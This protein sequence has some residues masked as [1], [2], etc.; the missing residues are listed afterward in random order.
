MA[1]FFEAFAE[2]GRPDHDGA[3][4]LRSAVAHVLETPVLDERVDTITACCL[5][6]A[7][8]PF[9][10]SILMSTAVRAGRDRSYDLNDDYFLNEQ[11]RIAWV[12]DI[13]HTLF[14]DVRREQ[15]RWG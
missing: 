12:E 14:G 13:A 10:P 4:T 3:Q 7:C 6:H 11:D 1:V 9:V 15:Y 2:L 8:Y 5:G